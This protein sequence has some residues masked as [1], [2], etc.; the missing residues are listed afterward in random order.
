VS[1]VATARR[2]YQALKNNAE[3]VATIRE[4][5]AAVALLIATNPDASFELTSSTVNGQTFSGKRTWT[6]EDRLAHL[7]QLV[8]MFDSERPIPSKTRIVFPSS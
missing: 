8:E 2:V 1:S 4:E 3:A 5:H 6:N 7:A